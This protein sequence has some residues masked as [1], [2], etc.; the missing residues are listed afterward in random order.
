MEAIGRFINQSPGRRQGTILAPL[1]AWQTLPGSG[2]VSALGHLRTKTRPRGQ[3]ITWLT[4]LYLTWRGSR[5]CGQYIYTISDVYL[6]S[7]S[8]V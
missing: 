2:A 8:P 4:Q 1:A 5:C 3:I 6:V 7:Q